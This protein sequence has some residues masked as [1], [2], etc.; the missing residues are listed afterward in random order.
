M[1]LGRLLEFAVGRQPQAVAVVDGE[2]RVTYGELWHDVVRLAGALRQLGVTRGD[3]IAAL[4]RNRL[5]AVCLFWASQVLGAVVAPLNPRMS[6]SGVQRCLTDVE[7]K[8][9]FFDAW[10]ENL[11]QRVQVEGKPLFVGV[12]DATADCVVGGDVS[13]AELLQRGGDLTVTNPGE[14]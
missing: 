4:L 2:R 11:V 9:I 8:L 7:P 5:E 12:A 1:N 14:D 3:R 10:T 6:Q 13:Y